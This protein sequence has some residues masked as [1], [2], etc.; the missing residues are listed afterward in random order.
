MNSTPLMSSTIAVLPLSIASVR[1]RENSGAVETWISP[2]TR[3]MWAPASE[4]SS[5]NSKWGTTG[6]TPVYLTLPTTACQRSIVSY[7]TS[8]DDN[9]LTIDELGR[10]IGMTVRNI[11]AHQSRGLLPP[12]AL[13]GRTGY[14]GPDHIARL[15]LIQ[16]LQ[17]EGFNLDLI[18]RLLDGRG[19][20]EQRRAALPP[21]AAEGLAGRGARQ[22]RHRRAHRRVGH[23]RSVAAVQGARRG[24]HPPAARWTLRGPQPA[25]GQG[26]ARAHAGSACPSSARST[27][28]PTCASRPTTSRRPTSTSSSRPSGRRS[29]RSA[30]RRRAGRPCRRRWIACCRWP[31][32]R[33]WRSSGWR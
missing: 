2:L 23:G 5:E 24:P 25:P 19:R 15:E 29:S 1:P 3:M 11:R 20:L 33:C 10:K 28:P 31:P 8:N 7:V 18:K 21:R 12:P 13:R 27:S 26:G 4:L 16:E 32:T 17:S 14:Y 9:E 22:R 6:D 30:R